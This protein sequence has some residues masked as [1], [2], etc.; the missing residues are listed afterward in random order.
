MPLVLKAF[1]V[2]HLKKKTPPP[3]KPPHK[4]KK[5]KKKRKKNI[6]TSTW[7]KYIFHFWLP[8]QHMEFLGQVSDLS[9]SHDLSC[10]CG[11]ARALTHCARRRLNLNPSVPKMP[12]ILLHHSRNSGKCIFKL[13]KLLFNVPGLLYRRFSMA[14]SIHY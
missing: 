12:P 6:S 11:K 8:P 5:K 14:Y 1:V 9:L 4:K 10:M 13:V 3:K 7:K 2:Q